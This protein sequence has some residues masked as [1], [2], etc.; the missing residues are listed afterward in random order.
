MLQSWIVYLRNGKVFVPTSANA[1]YF[2]QIDPVAVVPANNRSEIIAA[3][4]ST[5]AKGNPKHRQYLRGHFPPPVVLKP[6]GVKTWK[7]FEKEAH[8]WSINL[9]DGI[10]QICP[11]KDNPEGGWIDDPT[12]VEKLPLGTTVDE[13]AEKVAE[14][15]VNQASAIGFR[16]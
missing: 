3:I 4:K 1:G 6:A 12:K 13:V 8:C 11:K 14:Q 7:A 9:R 16:S 15:I 5:I 10:F 2:L